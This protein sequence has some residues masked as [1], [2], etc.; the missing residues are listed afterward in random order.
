MASET[1]QRAMRRALTLAAGA[2][3][4]TSPNPVVGAVVLDRSG[5]IVGEGRHEAYGGPHAEIEALRVA[6]ERAVGGTAVVSLEPCDHTGRTGPCSEAL[7][8]AEVARVVY[9]VDDP[10]GVGG[11]G[12]LRSAGV[13]VESGVLREEAERVNEAWLTAVRLG[14]PHVHLKLATSL[15]GRV[16]AAD[17]TSRWITG[18]R[19]RADVHRLRHEVDAVLVGTGTALADDPALTVRDLPDGA[20]PDH[21]PLRVLLGRRDLPAN[22]RLFDGQA[23]TV[24]MR[25]HTPASALDELYG[26]GVRSVLV[27]GG[28][29]VAAAFV[30]AGLVDRVSVYVAPVLLGAGPTALADAGIETIADALRLHPDD[31]SVLGEDV[32]ISARVGGEVDREDEGRGEEA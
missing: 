24:L 25:Q 20:E 21:Q 26:R 30:A 5:A 31:V 3:G 15:D 19:S 32:R 14:R 12:H 6:G 29:T 16:A 23:E 11:A 8:A 18:A 9:A 28:P 1:E 22:S 2:L 7:L 13:D 17:G 4:R 27:E 10:T